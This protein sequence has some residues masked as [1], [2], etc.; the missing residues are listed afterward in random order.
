M[1]TPNF[2]L[3]TQPVTDPVTGRV[4]GWLATITADDSDTAIQRRGRSS[5][6]AADAARKA[7]GGHLLDLIKAANQAAAAAL[8]YQRKTAEN[9]E[10][11]KAAFLRWH[12]VDPE[13]LAIRDVMTLDA[14]DE[15][16]AQLQFQ[17]TVKGLTDWYSFGL[18]AQGNPDPD[19]IK[20][21]PF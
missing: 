2:K 3:E 18:D 10:A 20:P 13:R 11:L 21:L 12:D 9:A 14:D 17:A 8:S 19:S 16:P 4:T 5:A 6:E 1:K 7:L 15:S